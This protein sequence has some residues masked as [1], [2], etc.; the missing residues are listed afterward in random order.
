MRTKCLGYAIGNAIE[1][2]SGYE[3]QHGLALAQGIGITA[4]ASAKLKWCSDETS[5]RIINALT[6]NDLPVVCR[7]FSAGLISQVLMNGRGGDFELV[8]PSEIGCCEIKNIK[9]GELECVISSG[10]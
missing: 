9:A 2:L 10:M 7:K 5:S 4:R 8:V 3:I 1:A 6:K